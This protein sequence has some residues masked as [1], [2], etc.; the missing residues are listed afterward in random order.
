M[1]AKETFEL[2]SELIKSSREE[3]NLSQR[4]LA[5]ALAA[6]SGQDTITRSD[7]SR[8][9]RGKR[10]P[11]RH[12]LNWISQVLDVPLS[13]LEYAANWSRRYRT[14]TDTAAAL[15]EAHKVA[16]LSTRPQNHTAPTAWE[17]PQDRTG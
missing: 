7:V 10:I 3:N 17:Y 15:R 6:A 9:E 8:W 2:I 12:W 5:E 16:P 14:M 11:T 4:R 1:E 13:R